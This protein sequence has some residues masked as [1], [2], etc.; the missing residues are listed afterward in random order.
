ME[1]WKPIPIG[2]CKNIW[3]ES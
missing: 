3:I 2:D 1:G